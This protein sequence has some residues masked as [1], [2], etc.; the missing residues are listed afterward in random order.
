[1]EEKNKNKN[2]FLTVLIMFMVI[3]LTS[4]SLKVVSGSDTPD[5]EIFSQIILRIVLIF[6]IIFTGIGVYHSLREYDED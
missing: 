4:A 3:F 1:M 5:D 6:S 2:A